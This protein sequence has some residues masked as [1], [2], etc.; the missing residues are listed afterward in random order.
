MKIV[1][2]P[3][4]INPNIHKKYVCV[5]ILAIVC[6]FFQHFLSCLFRIQPLM[7]AIITTYLCNAESRGAHIADRASKLPLQSK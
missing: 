6:Q 4:K 7:K 2:L 5:L 1:H 3:L